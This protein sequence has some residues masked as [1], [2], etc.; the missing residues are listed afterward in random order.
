M[1]RLILLF[2][3][4]YSTS[5]FSQSVAGKVLEI[6]ND[7]EVPLVGAN[8]FLLDKSKGDISDLTGDF[9]IENIGNA[10]EYIVSYVGYMN[11]TLKIDNEYS[12]IILN[13][14]SNLDEINIS[15]KEKTSSV[16]LLSSTNLLKISSEELLKAA[17]C[18]LAESFET[19]PSIDVNFSDAISGRKQINMLGLAS[20]NILISIEN[21]PSI[22]GALN[23]YGLTFIP[24]TW[25]ESIQIAK[26]SGSVVNGYE[27]ISGQI[28]AE[29]R[30]PLTD[31]KFFINSYYNSMERFELNTHYS[32]KLTEKIDYGLYLHADK[33]DNRNDH[34]NDNFGDSPTGQQINILNRFQYTNAIKG[35]IGFF[36]INYV[37][38][39]RVYGEID[40]FDP[41]IMPGPSVNDSWGG[42]ADSNI[43][44]STLKFGYVNPEITYRS[45][46]LQLSYSNVD[47]GAD[48]GNNFHDT[49]HT[50]FFSNLIYNSII[51]DTRS[52]IKT[53]ISFTHDI[54][55][56]SV[57]NLN[58]SFLD[59]D[60][61]EKSIGAYFEYNYDDLDKLNLS[62]GIRYDH[63]NIIGNFISP[64]L[65]VRY[66]ALPKTTIKISAGKA[67]R[68]ANLFSENQKL[69][70]SSRLI[71]F[72]SVNSSSEFSSYDYFDM[73][74]EVAWNY[75]VS[76]IQSF[77]LFD[78]DSQFVID[79]Y[80][81]DFENRVIIDWESPSNILFYNLSG[82]SYAK[83]FQAQ[84]SYPLSN[85]F[86]LLFAYKN[87]D[88][89]TDYISGRLE[90]PL[91]PSNRFFVNFSYDGPLNDKLRKWKFDLTYNHLGKQ[92]IPS[93]I[94]NPEIFRLDPF[95][96]KLD[97]IN[98]QIT[99]VFSNSFEVYLGVENLTNYKQMDGIISNSDPFSQ[100]FDATMIYGPVSGRMS[101]LGLRYTIK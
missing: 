69:F 26:G 28:N 72:T 27:S 36:D 33:K 53:G 10:K 49:R 94:Q 42:S 5:F 3:V 84:F 85:S 34:N 78:R 87:T 83:S 43:I 45:L 7:K 48:F 51:G 25:I 61:S 23:A 73:N 89:K 75:G 93:T 22:R 20:P 32:T 54:Y 56:E 14:N 55:D 86:D 66:Q 100:Y 39:E 46:G 4:F 38:D 11:D 63:H 60:R 70:F 90:N 71:N 67:H 98:S 80:I 1:K 65:H 99:R 18:N 47:Q 29:L 74:P 95:S 52:K 76:L 8:V 40:Y 81:T 6:V 37:G 96:S 24:G 82:R 13:K 12:K 64:R 68:I 31:N 50:S 57:N 44:R 58:T 91:T 62:A 88:A 35:L 101:Y 92:R 15:F 77:K 17:C 16:S 41:A 79:Y 21:I 9:L 59:L 2:F 19:T 30:K 97:L